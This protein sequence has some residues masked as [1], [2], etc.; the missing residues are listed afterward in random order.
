MDTGW[1]ILVKTIRLCWLPAA[2]ATIYGQLDNRVYC[3][4]LYV[5]MRAEKLPLVGSFMR[6]I[7]LALFPNLPAT[8]FIRILHV[9]F[10]SMPKQSFRSLVKFKVR[11]CTAAKPGVWCV[12]R[13]TRYFLG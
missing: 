3:L 11:N 4:I 1:Q 2:R 7:S 10:Q 6:C 8:A 13:P 5:P 9:C 12:Q